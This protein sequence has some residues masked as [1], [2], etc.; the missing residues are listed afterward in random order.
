MSWEMEITRQKLPAD[1]RM[2][3]HEMVSN[4]E[5]TS[6]PQWMY[7]DF[8][9]VPEPLLKLIPRLDQFYF[10][11]TY[12]KATEYLI[13]SLPFP[14]FFIFFLPPTKPPDLK[15]PNPIFPQSFVPPS[16]H[17][18]FPHPQEHVAPTFLK[19]PDNP[20]PDF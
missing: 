18:Q 13:T 4:E 9:K 12:N 7:Q 14:F 1:K 17:L 2:G 19:N 8:L 15:H 20:Y 10:P 16:P 3:D 5:K 11:L 6:S